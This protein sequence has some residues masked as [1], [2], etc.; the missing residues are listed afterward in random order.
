MKSQ[1][2][3]SERV[4]SEQRLVLVPYWCEGRVD[5]VTASIPLIRPGPNNITFAFG[6]KETI[7]FF[8]IILGGD[9]EVGIA[10]TEKLMCRELPSVMSSTALTLMLTDV[11]KGDFEG[12]GGGGRTLTHLSS[13]TLILSVDPRQQ[14]KKGSATVVNCSS[15]LS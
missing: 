15:I 8:R 10:D 12:S 11:K 9:A 1:N 7:F 6:E 3:T 14:P 4:T 13:Y 5:G 2:I